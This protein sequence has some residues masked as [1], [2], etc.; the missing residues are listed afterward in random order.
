MNRPELELVT[1]ATNG[2]KKVFCELFCNRQKYVYNLLFQLTDYGAQ[3]EGLAQETF[4]RVYETLH[5][6]RA[7]ASLRTWMCRIAVNA[8]RL[9]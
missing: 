1:E 7:E 5:S 8:F 4:I 2:S 9:L 3:A 6:F